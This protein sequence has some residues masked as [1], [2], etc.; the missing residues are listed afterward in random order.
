M[1]GSVGSAWSCSGDMYA[2]VPLS[3]PPANVRVVRSLKSSL[4]SG[5]GDCARPKSSTFTRPSAS[6]MM[7]R[8]LRS[9]WTM[10]RR[11]AALT[12]S[13]TGTAIRMS[14]AKGSP[15]AGIVS[16]RVRP[17]TSSMVRKRRPSASSM[18]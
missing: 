1:R 14:S 18:E 3:T 16:A 9:R 10:P 17:E 15:S 11:C 4:A 8:G 12:A 2:S 13:A 6:T 7:L 5:G